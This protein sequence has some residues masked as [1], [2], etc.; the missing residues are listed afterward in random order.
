MRNTVASMLSETDRSAVAASVAEAERRT[1]AEIAIVLA[2][3]SSDYGRASTAG[4]MSLGLIAATLLALI[5]GWNS[6]WLFLLLF[7]L[8]YPAARLL[9]HRFPVLKRLFITDAELDEEVMEAASVAFHEHG[10]SLTREQNAVL[11]YLS[12]FEHRVRIMADTGLAAKEM[13]ADFDSVAS[14]LAGSMRQGRAAQ[15]LCVAVRRLGGLAAAHY[16]PRPDDTNELR[17]VIVG[18]PGTNPP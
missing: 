18:R 7:A 13:Q 9:I 10:L 14:E 2:D 11:V 15:G 5:L 4:A 1:S 6:M 16:P 3:S 8:L 12:A 17:N